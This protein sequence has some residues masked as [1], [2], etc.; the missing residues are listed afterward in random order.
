M[1]TERTQNSFGKNPPRV[2]AQQEVTPQLPH[3]FIDLR[4]IL[5]GGVFVVKRL[6]SRRSVESHALRRTYAEIVNLKKSSALFLS[7]YP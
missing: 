6:I 2:F 5:I 1:T 7:S 4:S 3:S